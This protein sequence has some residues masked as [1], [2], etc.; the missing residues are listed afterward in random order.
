MNLSPLDTLLLTALVCL[1]FFIICGIIGLS[2][3]RG[4]VADVAWGLGF[5]VVSWTSWIL[6]S[7]TLFGAAVNSLVTVWGIRLASHIYLRNR[8]RAED[9]RYLSLRSQWKKFFPL[10]FFVQ[11]F[12][13]QALILFAVAF[14]ILWIHLHPESQSWEFFTAAALLWLIGFFYEAV[15]DYQLL[16]FR[17]K[18]REA[19]CTEGLWKT[20][21]HPNYFGE[22][23][24]W[25]AV[26]AIAIPAPYGLLLIFSPS[27]ITFVI[28]KIV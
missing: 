20:S 26:W 1:V 22:I 25:W 7:P 28:L 3:K 17:K 2:K 23:L 12:L 14:P 21:R 8:N 9:F 18:D 4:D 27:L 19:L 16:H 6:S 15:G 5:I 24:Q 13:L 11:I 10:R